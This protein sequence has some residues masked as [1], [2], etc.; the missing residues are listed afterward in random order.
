MFSF[1]DK[2]DSNSFSCMGYMSS[3]SHLGLLIIKSYLSLESFVNQEKEKTE[4]S[5][6]GKWLTLLQPL[7]LQN[8]I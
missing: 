2:K 5:L 7:N 3:T 1:I 4:D 8:R 6:F